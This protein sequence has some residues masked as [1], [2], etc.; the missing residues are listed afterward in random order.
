MH[1]SGEVA[2]LAR[3]SFRS[4][5]EI[6]VRSLEVVTSQIIMYRIFNQDMGFVHSRKCVCILEVTI[7][8]CSGHWTLMKFRER[9][10]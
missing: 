10:E 9:K 5:T 8:Q 2:T 3:C 7:A 4:R 1:I 6:T